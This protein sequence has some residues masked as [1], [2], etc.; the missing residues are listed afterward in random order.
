MPA[1]LE[2]LPSS[3]VVQPTAAEAALAS[4]YIKSAAGEVVALQEF[5]VKP[6]G[7]VSSARGLVD[8]TAERSVSDTDSL[9]DENAAVEM[10]FDD[11]VLADIP[12]IPE[13]LQFTADWYLAQKANG[14]GMGRVAPGSYFGGEREA[15]N[16]FAH[17]AVS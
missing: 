9:W 4:D 5:K 14:L 15:V 8:V 10:S 17:Y 2:V 6:H 13:E 12:P 1:A 7:S 3:T 11:D 16:P